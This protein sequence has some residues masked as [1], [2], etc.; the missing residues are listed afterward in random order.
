M[1]QFSIFNLLPGFARPL[2]PALYACLVLARYGSALAAQP[3]ATGEDGPTARV[4]TVHD[5]GATEAFR[6]RPARI[7]AM[8]N[9]AITNLTGKATVAEAWRSLAPTQEV[10]GIKVYSVAGPNSGTRPAV[11]AAVVEGLLAAGLPPKHIIVWDKQTSDLRAARRPDTIR[12]PCTVQNS[13]C[14]ETWFGEISSSARR[15]AALRESRSTPS[16]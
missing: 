4:V 15:D 12:E 10:V 8:V 6:P 7:Q 1:K 9:R 11:V 16:S 3:F 2:A 14:W 5:A 13:R